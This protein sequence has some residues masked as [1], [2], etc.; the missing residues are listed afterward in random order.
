MKFTVIAV[1][2]SLALSSGTHVSA[3]D[4]ARGRVAPA[5]ATVLVRDGAGNFHAVGSGVLVRPDGVLLTAY[6][7]VRGAREIQVRLADGETYDRAELVAFDE[8]RNVA[9]LRIAATRTP[10]VVVGM[11]DEAAVGAPVLAVFNV[12]SRGGVGSGG[13]LS[14]ITLADEIPAAGAGFR[15]LKF[16][17]GVPAEAAGG[18]LV[19][20]A[21]RALGL[22][23]PRAQS[24]TH[25][26]AVPLFNVIGLVR[27]IQTAQPA[28]ASVVLAPGPPN[29]NP[30]VPIRQHSTTP[31]APM[32]QVAVPQRATLPLQAAGPGSVVVRET[33]PAKLLVGSR[34][35][36]VTSRSNLF[37][38]VQLV[39]ELRKRR[40]LTDWNLSLVDER[41]VADLILEIDHVPLTWEFNYSV[42]HQRSGVIV[43]AGKVYA[44]GGGDGATLMAGRVVDKLT[45]LRASVKIENK[46]EGGATP[47]P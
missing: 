38:P 46:T 36:Y 13:V 42:T 6:D 20:G 3:Q 24:A 37:R 18:V 43:S 1:L 26:Y 14:S 9:A 23:V 44:W 41:E 10:F 17:A 19:D 45:K 39:N 8:R 5:V 32:P 25:G 21:G 7:L 22:I 16:N 40:E 2:V 33:D 11:A 27:S 15:V 34:T 4:E 28:S 35:L 31:I 29:L 47:R 12:G 30:A